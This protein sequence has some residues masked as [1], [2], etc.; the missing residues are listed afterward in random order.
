MQRMFSIPFNGKASTPLPIRDTTSGPNAPDLEILWFPI[1]VLGFGVPTPKGVHGVS[2]VCLHRSSPFI[3]IP[4]FLFPPC[5]RISRSVSIQANYE[6]LPSWCGVLWLDTGC[7]SAE[8]REF[9]KCTIEDKQRL[10][11]TSR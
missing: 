8:A 5:I 4:S 2:I 11:Q 6:C 1:V 10:R 7:S 9:W 3:M